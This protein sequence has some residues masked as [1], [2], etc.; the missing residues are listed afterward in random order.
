MDINGDDQRWKKD[1]ILEI[2]RMIDD[3]DMEYVSNNNKLEELQN[4]FLDRKIES[5]CLQRLKRKWRE[6]DPGKYSMIYNG[7]AWSNEHCRS[8]DDNKWKMEKQNT[9]IEI[10][11]TK[12]TCLI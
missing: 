1:K 12:N 6:T 8:G 5:D 4:I 7:V 9:I 11:Q 3:K 10:D 2:K